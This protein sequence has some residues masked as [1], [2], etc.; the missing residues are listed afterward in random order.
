[1][2][3]QGFI[4]DFKLGGGK[5]VLYPA[6]LSSR[7]EETI[8]ICLLLWRSGELGVEVREECGNSPSFNSRHFLLLS[9]PCKT[10]SLLA[11]RKQKSIQLSEPSRCPLDKLQCLREIV[12]YTKSCASIK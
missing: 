9:N 4:Q 3:I 11:K 12:C 6:N 10:S 2:L 7:V 1:M 5:P 8:L